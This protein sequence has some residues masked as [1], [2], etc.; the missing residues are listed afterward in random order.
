M[1]SHQGLVM[2]IA[3]WIMGVDNDFVYLV[4]QWIEKER[5]TLW[6]W[7]VYCL[8]WW[9]CFLAFRCFRTQLRCILKFYW[10]PHLLAHLLLISLFLQLLFCFLSFHFLNFL[11]FHFGHLFLWW[12]FI[13]LILVCWPPFGFF[14]VFCTFSL[15]IHLILILFQQGKYIEV[16][17]FEIYF[18]LIQT[19]TNDLGLLAYGLR[20]P[21]YFLEYCLHQRCLEFGQLFD[22][23]QRLLRLDPLH[24]LRSRRFRLSGWV[25]RPKWWS[26]D[27]H[28]DPLGVLMLS[29]LYVFLDLLG[30][31]RLE[32]VWLDLKVFVKIIKIFDVIV[33]NLRFLLLLGQ[34]HLQYLPHHSAHAGNWLR[35][36]QVWH[37]L[38][39]DQTR[40][41][42]RAVEWY[43]SQSIGVLVHWER[44]WN[45]FL[46]LCQNLA[47]I[48][49]ICFI[50]VIIST[51]FLLLAVAAA[52]V[53]GH[54]LLEL[55]VIS[56][57]KRL[58]VVFK[59]LLGVT[60]GLVH[61]PN[62]VLKSL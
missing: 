18:L 54:F 26:S 15:G 57:D 23:V 1:G 25:N 52:I 22:F 43:L 2:T 5:R 49:W 51:L 16:F 60:V 34:R 32:A 35:I 38:L 42:Q 39:E 28:H 50:L 7:C 27:T 33:H 3:K 62:L 53:L 56:F 8:W 47:L 48:L 21:I 20:L 17:L 29:L 36:V 44:W 6:I 13:L 10:F 41:F 11:L 58:E 19:T 40:G 14:F 31:E 59:L 12:F 45:C 24:L 4:V 30:V 46:F 61:G 55:V 9:F 37:L